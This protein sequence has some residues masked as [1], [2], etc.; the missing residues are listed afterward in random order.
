MHQCNK[1][2]ENGVENIVS[3]SVASFFDAQAF[4]ALIIYRKVKDLIN[5]A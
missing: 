4:S 2:V 1:N 3:Q 5:S